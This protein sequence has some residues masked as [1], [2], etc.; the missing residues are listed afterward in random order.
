MLATG[1]SARLALETLVA[2]GVHP[3]RVV[4]INVVASP[5]VGRRVQRTIVYS[6]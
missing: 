5:E 4:F 3:S 2:A 1:G 6:D